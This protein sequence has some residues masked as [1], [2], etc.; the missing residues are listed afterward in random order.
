MWFDRCVRHCLAVLRNDESFPRVMTQE[1]E[2]IN[3]LS[4]LSVCRDFERAVD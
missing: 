4:G 3:P 1:A 2:I